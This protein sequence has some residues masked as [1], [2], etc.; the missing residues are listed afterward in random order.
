MTLRTP[1]LYLQSGS[2]TAEND[3]LGISG[4]VGTSG[5]SAG[6]TD[7]QVTQ[8][9]TPAMTVSVNTGHAW[10]A[11]TTSTTQGTYHTFNDAAVTLTI[12]TAPTVNTRIDLVCLTIRD[13]AYSGSNNDCI[14]QVITGTAAASPSVP[15][16]PASSIALA[17]VLVGT[18]V[19]SIVNANITDVRVRSSMALPAIAAAGSTIYAP[20]VTPQAGLTTSTISQSQMA[21]VLSVSTSSQTITLPTSGITPGYSTTFIA[22]AVSFTLAVPSGVTVYG[23]PSGTVTNASI[24]IPANASFALYNVSSSV[25]YY[26]AGG[27]LPKA[28][29]SSST[30]SPTTGANGN[31]TAYIFKGTGTFTVTAGLLDVCIVGGG[32]GG[33]GDANATT[34]CHGGGGAGGMVDT[35]AS[36]NSLYLP[37]GTYTVTVGAGGPGSGN[38]SDSGINAV[39]TGVGGGFGNALGSQYTSRAGTGGSGGGGD[40]CFYQNTARSAGVLSQGN[41]GGD[42][43]NNSTT[44]NAGGGGGGGAGAVGGTGTASVGGNGG[45]GKVTTIIPSTLATSASVGQVVS[46]SVYFSGGGGG[47]RGAGSPGSGGTGGGAAGGTTTGA[48]ATAY[49]GG[50]GGGSVT[51]NTGG[52]GGSGVV[53]LLIG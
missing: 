32:G 36:G 12:A 33:G 27:A 13:S 48:A 37:A 3:R 44:S 23:T 52:A 26:L 34:G 6:T 31:K 39:I 17:Q 42:A 40:G 28:S 8:S 10:V 21:Q 11:G 35:L 38:G 4:L 1:P 16:T 5:V 14:L 15:A 51:A 20:Y 45:V 46:T 7:L 24:T 22:Q 18:N 30:G 2:H 41:A 53:I 19:T 49:T 43:N 29:V 9:A 25:W 50:G 47:A